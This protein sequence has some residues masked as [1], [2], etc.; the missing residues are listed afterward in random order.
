MS[1]LPQ[2][3]VYIVDDDISVREA[4]SD[5]LDS[6][7][8]VSVLYASADDFLSSPRFDCPSCLILDVRMPGQ[9]G[10]EL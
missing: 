3:I 1:N 6:V 9:S 2:S 7:G 8:I 5:L 4:L 10:L